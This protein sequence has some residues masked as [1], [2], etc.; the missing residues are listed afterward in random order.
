MKS[1]IIDID[2]LALEIFKECEKD[3]EPVTMEEAKEMAQMEIGARGMSREATSTEK[4]TTPAEKKKRTVKI[5][6]EKVELFTLLW[7]AVSAKYEGA[8]ITKENKNISVTINGKTFKVDL[9]EQR[10]KKGGS[11]RRK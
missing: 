1:K 11:A 7:E 3:G 10:A 6:D 9:I 5:S 8:E 2:K 4:K